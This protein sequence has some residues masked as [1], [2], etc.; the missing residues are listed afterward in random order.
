MALPVSDAIQ[1]ALY[2]SRRVLCLYINLA[3]GAY[4]ELPKITTDY[5]II[6]LNKKIMNGKVIDS[7]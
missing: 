3:L 6:M 4:Q 2:V 1:M 5:E 7:T